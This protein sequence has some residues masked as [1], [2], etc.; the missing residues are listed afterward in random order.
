MKDWNYEKILLTFLWLQCFKGATN[1]FT[2][3][4]RAPWC[5]NSDVH[6]FHVINECIFVSLDSTSCNLRICE[7]AHFDARKNILFFIHKDAL[8]FYAIWNNSNFKIFKWSCC[9]IIHIDYITYIWADLVSFYS[10]WWLF[11]KDLFW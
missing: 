11:I 8:Q 3:Y 9:K 2:K 6:C 10:I 1:L 5:T 7:D 4:S